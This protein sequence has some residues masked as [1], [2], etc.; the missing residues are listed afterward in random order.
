L[1]LEPE[2]KEKP[3]SYSP[4]C[5]F[6]SPTIDSILPI[7][8]CP[9][10]AGPI[11]LHKIQQ[12][13]MNDFNKY[14]DSTK[15]RW[16]D[17]AERFRNSSHIWTGLFLLLIG[18]IALAKSFGVPI[19]RWLFSWQMLLI[20]IGLFSGFKKGFRDG[21]W[22]VPI[23]IGG[24]FL[25][26]DYVL[27]GD[28]RKHIWPLILIVV[29]LF[30]ILRPRRSN[31]WKECFEK[32]NPTS[33][34]IETITPLS[35]TNFSQDDVLDSTAIFGGTKKVI[36]SKNFKGGELVNIFGGAEIDFTQADIHGTAELDVTAIF[37]GATL[38]VPSHWVI[39][40]EAVTIFGGISDKR[41]NIAAYTD[42]PGKA[43]LIK[44]T[45]LFGGIEIKSY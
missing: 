41:K 26:N 28:M 8:C 13:T 2:G 24:I 25:I 42:G 35:E 5:F 18:G 12:N 43:L 37:G 32:K 34:G 7:G 22:F 33:G 19:P 30:F 39:K 36:L 44:G 1:C 6:H 4:V 14:S 10:A 27:L 9:I 21:G 3:P 31:K 29:G 23:I 38:I 17:S 40:Q 16:E 15:N 45:V 20:G 11:V